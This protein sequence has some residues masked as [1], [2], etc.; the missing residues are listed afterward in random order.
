LAIRP[1]RH[2]TKDSDE[3]LDSDRIGRRV[4]KMK[5]KMYNDK[6]LGELYLWM[7]VLSEDRPRLTIKLGGQSIIVESKLLPF[8]IEWPGVREDAPDKRV[9]PVEDDLFSLLELEDATTGGDDE[10]D[11]EEDAFDEDE[12]AD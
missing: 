7:S 5:A 2:L 3:P 1:E 11:E 6:Y 8:G 4:T 12:S 9:A 10:I